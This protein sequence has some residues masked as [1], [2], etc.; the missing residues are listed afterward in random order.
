MIIN[1]SR[2]RAFSGRVQDRGDQSLNVAVIESGCRVAE[3]DGDAAG[4]AG[5]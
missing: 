5:R 1:I 3:I 2:V 4:E